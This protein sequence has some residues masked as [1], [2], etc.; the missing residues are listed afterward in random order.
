VENEL[1]TK[2]EYEPGPTTLPPPA[3]VFRLACGLTQA[4]LAERAEVSLGT[5]RNIETRRHRPHRKTAER[6][7]AALQAD[8]LDLFPEWAGYQ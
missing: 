1:D 7:A 2:R 4:Q 6:I 3:K 8:V 5:V